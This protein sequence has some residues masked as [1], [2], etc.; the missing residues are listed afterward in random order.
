MMNLQVNRKMLEFRMMILQRSK[1][2]YFSKQSSLE[3]PSNVNIEEGE[4][5]H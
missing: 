2:I 1:L 4:S 5:K 3:T